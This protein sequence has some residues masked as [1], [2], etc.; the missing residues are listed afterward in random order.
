MSREQG[1]TKKDLGSTKNYL[2]EHQENNSGSREKKV[3]S[4]REPGAGDPPLRGLIGLYTIKILFS[5]LKGHPVK[6]TENHFSQ[7]HLNKI[8]S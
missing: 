7:L 5:R 1:D 4:Q 2:R 6:L 8:L 3:K